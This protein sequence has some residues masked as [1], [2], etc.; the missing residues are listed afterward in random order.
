MFIFIRTARTSPFLLSLSLLISS[1]KKDIPH[2]KEK[3]DHS[4]IGKKGMVVTAHPIASQIGL[5]IL[6]QGGNA[7]DAV[8]AVQFALAVVYPR[9]GNIGGGGFMVYRDSSG[10]ISS[11]DY[12]EK[13]PLAATRN[14]YLD[15]NKNVIEGLS[16]NGILASGVPGSVAGMYETSSEVRQ[17]S[18]LVKVG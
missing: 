14:M 1:C 17:N 4:V 5:N 8:V 13:A 2:I 7:A 16:L 12:R 18:T 11:L 6:K 15:S 9:A 10:E 3:Q